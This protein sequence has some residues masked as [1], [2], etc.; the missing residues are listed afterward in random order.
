MN[1]LTS[2][3]KLIA[4]ESMFVFLLC[5]SFGVSAFKKPQYEQQE[6]LGSWMIINFWAQWCKPCRQEIPEL[7]HLSAVLSPSNVKV[8]GINYD[9][10]SGEELDHALASLDIRFPQLDGRQQALIDFSIPAALPAT[11]I[12]SPS[13]EVEVSLIGLQSQVSILSAL[14]S[15]NPKFVRN[16]F[17]NEP[18]KVTP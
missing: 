2:I 18:L 8:Y 11:Y 4:I 13:G 3:L 15:V 14:E 1:N 17:V 10:I 12:V 16:E 7:N 5:A 9:D 6:I